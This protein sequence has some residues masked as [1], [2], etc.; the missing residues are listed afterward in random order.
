MRPSRIIILVL[1]AAFFAHIA[2]YVPQLPATIA[3]H[4]DGAGRADGWM[5]RNA[6]LILEAAILVLLFF[7]FLGIPWLIELLPERWINLP[8]R[9]HWLS[10]ERRASSFLTIRK[11]FEYFAAVSLALL[12]IANHL[13]F[14]ANLRGENLRSDLLIVVLTVYFVFVAVWLIMLIARFSRIK[15]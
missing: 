6:F 11:F 10:A 13:V 2:Y 3:S 1:A 5:S 12:M 15:N 7:E 4:F 9:D 14:N 8:N